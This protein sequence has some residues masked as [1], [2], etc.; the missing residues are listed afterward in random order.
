MPWKRDVLKR[1][2]V[3]NYQRTGKIS[4]D[5]CGGVAELMGLKSQLINIPAVAI[6][7]LPTPILL[8]WLDSFA[9]IYF[10]TEQELVF[11]I[12]EQGIT[13][14]KPA[15]FVEAWGDSGQVLLLQPTKETPKKRFGLSWFLPAIKKHKPEDNSALLE[16]VNNQPLDSPVTCLGDGH[17]GVW[18][19]RARVH[20]H[21]F[22]PFP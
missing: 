1:A 22:F 9:I 14:K 12:P 7:K 21:P 4:I 10:A 20:M 16:W 2:L 13:R 8:P 5:L 18:K 17:D 11:A 19:I 15:D 6:S 3:N